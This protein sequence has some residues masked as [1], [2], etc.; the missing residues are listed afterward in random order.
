M[1][2]LAIIPFILVGCSSTPPPQHYTQQEQNTALVV[3]REITVL[4]RNEVINGVKECE[5][6]GL[7]PVMVTARRRINGFLSTAPVDVTCAPRYD[8]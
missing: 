3:D 5:G 2:A 8:K 1:K 4:T 6:S 7:R